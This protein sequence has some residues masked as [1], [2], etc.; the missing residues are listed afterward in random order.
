M[1][2]VIGLDAAKAKLA[3]YE[4]ALAVRMADVVA[5]GA[6]EAQKLVV[7]GIPA[8]TGRARLALSEA[9]AVEVRQTRDG[10]N[11]YA[12]F[13][14]LTKD[15]Q[16]KTYYLFFVEFGTKGYEAGSSRKAGKDRRGKEREQKVKRRI[17]A[18]PARPFFRTAIARLRPWLVAERSKAHAL[19]LIDMARGR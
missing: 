14:P 9:S 8:K 1:S 10:R 13:G 7:A 5:R 2:E 18:R 11:A 16:K 6:K 15:L 19:A 17:P 4:Q 3:A 12:M